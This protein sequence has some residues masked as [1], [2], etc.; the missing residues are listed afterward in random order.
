M[1][2]HNQA[3]FSRNAKIKKKKGEEAHNS[4][5]E[6]IIKLNDEYQKVKQKEDTAKVKERVTFKVSN[7]KLC[8]YH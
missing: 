4:G 5:Q 3:K 6:S 1:T 2:L 8:P 7:E